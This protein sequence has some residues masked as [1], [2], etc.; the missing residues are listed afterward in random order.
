MGNWSNAVVEEWS[1]GVLEWLRDRLNLGQRWYHMQRLH[2][3]HQP[4]RTF[5]EEY[6]LQAD[7]AHFKKQMDDESYHF[8]VYPMGGRVAKNDRIKRLVPLYEQGRMWSAVSQHYT[9]VTGEVRDLVH[10]YE[11]EEYCAF[12]VPVHDDMLDVLSR[13]EDPE[14]VKKLKWPAKRKLGNGYTPPESRDPGLGLL[15]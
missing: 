4:L 10:D 2:Q 15:G 13:I 14:V 7:I 11:E 6:G 8:E 1:D 5:Y 12:P 9:D 3:K